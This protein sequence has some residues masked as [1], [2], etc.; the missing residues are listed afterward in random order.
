MADEKYLSHS[1]SPSFYAVIR[2]EMLRY[3]DLARRVLELSESVK[4]A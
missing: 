2:R 1:D 3:A 4:V